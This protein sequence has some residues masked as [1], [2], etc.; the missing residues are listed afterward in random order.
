VIT[1][2]FIISLICIIALGV[3]L[4]E[5]TIATAVILKCM[6]AFIKGNNPVVE[7]FPKQKVSDKQ[8]LKKKL[9]IESKIEKMLELG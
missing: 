7:L 3:V 6:N 4:A 9:E 8:N 5:V 1:E 2:I